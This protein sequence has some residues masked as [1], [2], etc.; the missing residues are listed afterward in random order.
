MSGFLGQLYT[1]AQNGGQVWPRPRYRFEG[2]AGNDANV[3]GDEITQNTEAATPFGQESPPKRPSSVSVEIKKVRP[4]P[5]STLGAQSPTSPL[6]TTPK[7]Q[8]RP[9]AGS[10]EVP[11]AI[12][13]AP[14]ASMTPFSTEAPSDISPTLDRVEIAKPGAKTADPPAVVERLPKFAVPEPSAQPLAKASLTS[15][16]ILGQA[17]VAPGP[18]RASAPNTPQGVSEPV[19]QIHIGRIEVRAPAA[20]SPAPRPQPAVSLSD[21]L[22]QRQRR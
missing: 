10:L 14:A 6:L 5:V 15:E 17:P 16:V 19:V 18:A 11:T 4:S 3:G 9:Q 20:P 22:A 12:P 7:L 13:A 2:S 1:T 8:P 21:Y